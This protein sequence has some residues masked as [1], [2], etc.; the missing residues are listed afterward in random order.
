LDE[1]VE[2]FVKIFGLFSMVRLMMGEGRGTYPFS[3]ED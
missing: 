2:F 3:S 1:F